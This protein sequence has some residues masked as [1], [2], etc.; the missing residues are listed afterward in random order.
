MCKNRIE[1]IDKNFKQEDINCTNISFK[2]CFSKPFSLHG[3]YKP[4]EE[5]RL[6]RLPKEF[7]NDEMIH[8]RLS[9]L[10]YHTAGGRL[11]FKTDSRSIAIR[12]ELC[13]P[14]PVPHIASTG[15]MGFD[16]FTK[17]DGSFG[18][19]DYTACFVPHLKADGCSFEGMYQFDGKEA[20]MREIT[21]HFPL[22]SKVSSLEVGLERGAGIAAPQPYATMLPVVFYGSSITQ[23]ACSSRPGNCYTA[24]LSRELD[25]DFINLGF[26]GNAY[27][28]R[29]VAEYIAGLSMC[30]LVL[31]YDY[32]ARSEQELADTHHAFYRTV[33]RH[34][35]DLPI[36]MMSA[37]VAAPTRLR[38]PQKRMAVSRL[39]VM[40]SFLEGIKSGDKNLYFIDGESLLGG[41]DARNTLVDSV[42]PNDVGFKNMADRIYPVLK[43]VLYH[44]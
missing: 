25:F 30:A 27:G 38:M 6:M 10:M 22:Y 24:V 39:I 3:F 11:R 37:P 31:E 8:A 14:E 16:M 26:S 44:F 34:N 5:Q 43:D 7:E 29:A 33:R 9:E 40:E 13:R 15:S 2:S 36:I 41:K 32:N 4:Y 19:P 35:P 21:I 12:A 23:G 18:I 28:D 42:H 1:E 20:V 17:P